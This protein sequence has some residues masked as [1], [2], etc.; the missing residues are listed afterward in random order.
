MDSDEREDEQVHRTVVYHHFV[1]KDG[2]DK[3]G[4]KVKTTK[5]SVAPLQRC[6]ETPCASECV[7]Q[8]CQAVR[9]CGV[10]LMAVIKIFS[11]FEAT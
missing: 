6:E 7:L 3:G 2:Y 1:F 10:E 8:S 5:A 4:G 11:E 9:E